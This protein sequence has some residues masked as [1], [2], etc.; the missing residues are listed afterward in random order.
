MAHGALSTYNAQLGDVRNALAGRDDAPFAL[1]H[2][3]L[4]NAS[5]I[6]AGNS[7]S[8]GDAL[9][10]FC[11]FIGERKDVEL[12]RP[13]IDQIYVVVPLEEQ[14]SCREA[15][16]RFFDWITEYNA[17][18]A[19]VG[20]YLSFTAGAAEAQADK[21]KSD[22][23]FFQA[24]SALQYAQKKQLDYY[25]YVPT[26]C[27]FDS[28]EKD[29]VTVGFIR[30]AIEQKRLR[31]AYQPIVDCRNDDVA[32]YECLLRLVQD[33][34]SLT[35]A[36]L[37]IPV[38]ERM[39]VVDLLDNYACEMALQEL[40]NYPDVTLAINIATL[41]IQRKGFETLLKGVK[42]TPY[43]AERLIIEITESGSRDDF[44]AILDFMKEF[45]KLGCRI[46]LDD[47]GVGHT[48][49]T[50]LLNMPVNIIKVDGKFV[51]NLLRA[52]E[53][54]LL[55]ETVINYSRHFDRKTVAEFVE[56]I[57]LAQELL[58]MDVD[59]LQG[60]YFRPASNNRLWLEDR[61]G[62]IP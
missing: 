10:K 45:Q 8:G 6:F 20:V 57:E 17:M 36:G 27:D 51:R 2:A 14:L 58:D 25:V 46:A 42:D 1:L 21:T 24:Y 39:G 54:K 52:P 18:E 48:S 49:F 30:R 56:T 29:R 19:P 61:V 12:F 35:P 38:A 13:A 31:F 43:I 5:D 59:Y 34:F 55:I 23:L 60:N 9:S 33:D 37:F 26:S 53:N 16:A 7:D 28:S 47:F 4:E 11:R 62:G 44:N 3:T 15:T 22:A 32:Y 41:T 40:R 50:Q